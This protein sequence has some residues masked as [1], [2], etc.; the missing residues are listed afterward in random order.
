MKL[1]E[2]YNDKD[3]LDTWGSCTIGNKS[4]ISLSKFKRNMSYSFEN[5]QLRKKLEDGNYYYENAIYYENREFIVMYE[6]SKF[7][8]A[9]G[10]ETINNYENG[11]YDSI[12]LA[13][14]KLIN[15]FNNAIKREDERE[16]QRI[17]LAR[18]NKII[19]DGKENIFTEDD[20]KEVYLV[21]LEQE[22]NLESIS[23]LKE[24]RKK[25]LLAI[26]III[27]GII[28]MFFI[29]TPMLLIGLGIINSLNTVISPTKIIRA[30][31]KRKKN[32]KKYSNEMGIIKQSLDLG[33][34]KNIESELTFPLEQENIENK[35]I[36]EI[37]LVSDKVLL[38]TSLEKRNYYKKRLVDLLKKYT[39]N[40]IENINS[41]S[42]QI[43]L[44]IVNEFTLARDIIS[45]L[46]SIEKEID[47]ELEKEREC[48]KILTDENKLMEKLGVEDEE[49]AQESSVAIDE[50]LENKS[51]KPSSNESKVVEKLPVEE[52]RQEMTETRIEDF[53]ASTLVYISNSHKV[54]LCRFDE[55][56]LNK[57][58]GLYPIMLEGGRDG[59]YIVDIPISNCVVFEDL[60]TAFK[61]AKLMMS[62]IADIIHARSCYYPNRRYKR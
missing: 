60:N 8:V 34:N 39:S 61:Y 38:I 6:G 33:I 2:I 9:L 37:N 14:K 59:Y 21:Y 36:N 40:Y 18:K 58:T 57:N 23:K 43:E 51:D 29:K 16:R 54:Y 10:E 1:L 7:H 25:S 46:A 15:E 62:N 11:E 31:I 30:L 55:V 52:S 4:R 24:I 32:L 12:T 44:S 27:I 28:P 47:G 3:G 48:S 5:G 50:T 53:K 17:E 22:Y 42:S 19:A 56:M 13:L 45:S 49:Q 35:V 20:A 41:S 26:L